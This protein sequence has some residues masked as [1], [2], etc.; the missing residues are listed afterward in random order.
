[1]KVEVNIKNQT[2]QQ[3]IEKIIKR[4]NNCILP[5]N[6]NGISFNEKGICNYCISFFDRKER[7]YL[8]EEALRNS[9][10]QFLKNKRNRN[11]DYDCMLGFSGGRDSTY[12]LY[13]LVKKLNLRV[14][15]YHVDNGFIPEQTKLNVKNAVEILNVKLIID[16]HDYLEKCVRHHILSWIHKPSLAMI[17]TFCI[18]CRYGYMK[19][20]ISYTQKELIPIYFSGGARS[21]K[22]NYRLNNFKLRPNSEGRFQ[23]FLGASIHMLKNPKVL[24]NRKTMIIQLKEYIYF[25]IRLEK[26]KRKLGIRNNVLRIE[27][28]YDYIKWD[29][30]QVTSVIENE[31][32]WKKN[33]RTESTWRGDCDIAL[34]KLYLYKKILG[35]N[36]KID[37]L[38]YL[39]RTNQIRRNEALERIKIEENVSDDVIKDFFNRLGLNFS[40]LE[41]AIRK[42]PK[43][44]N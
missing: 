43:I 42:V 24:L 18:G 1:M 27:P 29:E 20:P 37:G 22:V 3:S 31:L 41:I 25:F 4:C 23:M 13:Y 32:K 35:Y 30:K 12:L 8:G 15:A 40:D 44:N 34:L 6:Y 28:F 21:E 14:L 9:I 2:T 5:E 16:K 10:E 7:K 33:N 36:D 17:E 11:K 26:I 39:I 19:K 38:S